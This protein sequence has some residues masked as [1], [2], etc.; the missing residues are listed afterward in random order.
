[1][2]LRKTW[3]ICWDLSWQA[4]CDGTI[5]IGAVIT[6]DK[7]KILATGRNMSYGNRPDDTRLIYNSPL[8]HAEINAILSLNFDEID[9][10][11]CALYSMV[12]PCPLCIGAIC[13]SHIKKVRYASRDLWGGSTNLLTATPY[14]RRKEI[15]AVQLDNPDLEIAS[16]SLRFDFFL[17]KDKNRFGKVIKFWQDVEPKIS[18]LAIKPFNSDL[19][20]TMKTNN[21][22]SKEVLEEILHHIYK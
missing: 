15:I 2:E 12:E 19:L 6:D 14:L 3:E 18:K 5:P 8:A 16:L 20:Q 11:K 1:M 13:M 22:S 17:R 21:I 10:H 7:E 9:I 4:Y